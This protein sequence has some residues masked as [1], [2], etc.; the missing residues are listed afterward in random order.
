[1]E[2]APHKRPHI[3]RLH[4]DGTSRTGKASEGK[5]SLGECQGLWGGGNGGWLLYG[6]G[7][8]FWGEGNALELDRGQCTIL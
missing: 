1:M 8:S 6:D 3:T 5:N 7:A 4:L 2:E